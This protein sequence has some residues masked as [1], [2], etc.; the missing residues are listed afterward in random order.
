LTA[1]HGEVLDRC[2]LYRF[3]RILASG[4]H[5]GPD[6]LAGLCTLS[7]RGAVGIGT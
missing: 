4:Q 2:R 7:G 6:V 3:E 1:D 5:L